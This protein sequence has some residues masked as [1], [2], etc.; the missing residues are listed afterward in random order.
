[1]PNKRQNYI[2]LKI[3][4]PCLLI[5]RKVYLFVFISGGLS[6]SQNTFRRRTYWLWIWNWKA[7]GWRATLQI[8]P[9]LGLQAVRKIANNFSQDGR[10]PWEGSNLALT[11]HK[12]EAIKTVSPS[13]SSSLSLLCI[14]T[15]FSKFIFFVSCR[16]LVSLFSRVFSTSSVMTIVIIFIKLTIMFFFSSSPF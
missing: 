4:R 16:S 9:L 5:F 6:L 13:L 15:V 10:C 11:R 8:A 1:M 12:S 2:S 14:V 7:R 3:S